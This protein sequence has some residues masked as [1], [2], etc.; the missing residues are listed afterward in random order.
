MQNVF[1][2]FTETMICLHQIY[3]WVTQKWRHERPF[4]TLSYR[5][6]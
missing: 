3:D 6:S 4:L 2:D 1:F 5:P